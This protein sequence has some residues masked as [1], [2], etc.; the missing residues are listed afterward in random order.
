MRAI[1]LP[2]RHEPWSSNRARITS[3]VAIRNCW[4]RIKRRQSADFWPRTGP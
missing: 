2:W 1:Q 3:R 4:H